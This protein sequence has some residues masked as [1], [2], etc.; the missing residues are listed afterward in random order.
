MSFAAS[1]LKGRPSKV[2]RCL[3]AVACILAASTFALTPATAY[4]GA[5]DRRDNIVYLDNS[6]S[7]RPMVQASGWVGFDEGNSP[8][9]D[10]NEAVAHSFNCAGCR[11]VAVAVEVVIVEGNPTTVAP[12][13]VAIA[14]NENCQ[15]CQT[16]AYA[17]QYVISPH[18][19][20]S[21]DGSTWRQLWNIQ[22]Q[23]QQV[24]GS[25][26]DFPTMNSQL[27]QLS[28]QAFDIAS[29]AVLS[30][31]NQQGQYGPGQVQHRRLAQE[32]H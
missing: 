22:T 10:K 1:R 19:H 28:Q 20:V 32:Q 25:G 27:D 6:N 7:A 21:F 18:Y 14:Y 12:E 4:A 26:V 8:V 9:I 24:A 30:Q 23:I 16:F 2:R 11:T 17:N 5:G 13:N 3:S 31:G 15:S 29:K